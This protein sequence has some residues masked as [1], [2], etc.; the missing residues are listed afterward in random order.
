MAVVVVVVVVVVVA[1]GGGGDLRARLRQMAACSFVAY[2]W[3]C[4]GK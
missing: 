1:V 3:G 2:A 4:P